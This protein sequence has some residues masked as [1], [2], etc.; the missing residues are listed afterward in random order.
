MTASFQKQRTTYTAEQC[1]PLLQEGSNNTCLKAS[2]GFVPGMN[3]LGRR[4]ASY[5]LFAS[6]SGLITFCV[7]FGAVLGQLGDEARVMVRFIDM[8]EK[9]SMRF[10]ANTMK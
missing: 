3:L 4:D 10:V 2:V 6:F 9:V 1:Q 5:P 8:L 7:A